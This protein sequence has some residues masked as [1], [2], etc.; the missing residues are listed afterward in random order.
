MI[1]VLRDADFSANKLGTTNT[2]GTG[3]GSGSSGQGGVLLEYT[4]NAIAASGNTNLTSAQKNALNNLFIA[5]GAD[6][7]KNIM[8]KMKYIYLPILCNDVS[9]A[10]VNYASSAFTVDKVLTSEYWTKRNNG[11]VALKAG[12]TMSLTD[13]TSI[14]GKNMSA[15]FLRT[16]LMVTATNDGIDAVVALRGKTD[17]GTFIG[18]G[19]A[20]IASHTMVGLNSYPKDWSVNWGKDVDAVV[21]QY[22]CLSD[23]SFI[24]RTPNGDVSKSVSLENDLSSESTKTAYFNGINPNVNKAVG[25]IM[26]GE[27]LTKAEADNIADRIDELYSA[28]AS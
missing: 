7:S 22:Y 24:G 9:K 21:T 2:G 11:I 16:E 8:S 28:F 6:G 18:F 1:I 17:S 14:N 3:S 15:F 19:N 26:L 10:M 25:V 23:S 4:T 12:Q 13:S 20:S 5:L 27:A